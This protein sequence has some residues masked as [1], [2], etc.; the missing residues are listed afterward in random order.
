MK[1]HEKVTKSKL[2]VF[3]MKS[4]CN[5]V[6]L[7]N[8]TTD[9]I[10]AMDQDTIYIIDAHEVYH[11]HACLLVHHTSNTQVTHTVTVTQS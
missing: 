4:L 10:S 9:H 11:S 2:G 5:K 3:L 6:R 7:I 8:D 1:K